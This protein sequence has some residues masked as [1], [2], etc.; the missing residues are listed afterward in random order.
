MIRKM[1][2][3]AATMAMAST[4]TL[5]GCSEKPQTLGTAAKQD[6]AAYLGTGSP[7]VASGWKPGDKASWESH[8]RARA[9]GSQNDYSKAN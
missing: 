5:S 1:T 7:Y 8:L 9:Q 3:I 4:L 2:L 6:G